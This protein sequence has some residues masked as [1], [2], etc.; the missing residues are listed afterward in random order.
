MHITTYAEMTA[1]LRADAAKSPWVRVATLGKSAGGTR[2]LWLVRLA[3]P[4]ADPEKTT[5]LMV[6]CR[7]HGDEP[8]STEAVLRLIHRAASGGD[9]SLRAALAHET[10]YLVP[11][12]NPDGAG[13]NTRAN[14]NGTD[15]NRDWGVFSQPET[16]AVSEAVQ[17]IRPALIVDAHN[18]DGSDEYDADCIEIP[19]EMQSAKG[20]AS[21]AMQQL[22]VRDLAASGYAVHSTAWGAD[23]DPHLAH[24]WFQNR[25]ITSLL[26]ETHYGPVSDRADFERREGMYTALIHCLAKRNPAPWTA[27]ASRASEEASLFPPP[28]ATHTGRIAARPPHSA[29][30]LWAL[31]LY[32]LALW[33]MTLRRPETAARELAGVRPAPRYS[34]S[35]K[36]DKTETISCSGQRKAVSLPPR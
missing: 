6:L 15:L 11:M 10:L 14:H 5:R 4:A 21:H 27:Q 3:D 36:R 32:G 1:Q 34:Y 33:G 18:W 31:A 25:G 9:P 7:Q 20:R 29:R 2:D 26:V 19:R 23:T 28:L 30:W 35:R 22:A 13:A 17:Q 8:A 24:R 16:R 12:V